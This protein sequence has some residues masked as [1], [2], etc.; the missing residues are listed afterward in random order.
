MKDTGERVTALHGIG[1]IVFPVNVAVLKN[2]RFGNVG[3]LGL[4]YRKFLITKT[5]LLQFTTS[6]PGA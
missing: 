2:H 1:E 5:D 6:G 4:N 3:F